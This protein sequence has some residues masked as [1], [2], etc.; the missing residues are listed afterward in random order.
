MTIIAEKRGDWLYRWAWL[1]FDSAIWLVAIYGATWLRVDFQ[2]GPVLMGTPVVVPRSVPAVGG[3]FALVGMLAVRF[4]VRGWRSRHL[5]SRGDERRVIVF[6]A[7]DAGRRLLRSMM[8]DAG[9]GFF[10]IALL[11]DDKERD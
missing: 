2:F 10:P 11:D 8:H 7:G 9:S 5:A 6:G 3:S 1:P 4:V